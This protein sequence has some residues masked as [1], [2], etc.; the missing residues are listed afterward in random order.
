MLQEL[1]QTVFSRNSKPVMLAV[2]TVTLLVLAFNYYVHVPLAQN[3]EQ[4]ELRSLSTLLD[5]YASQ[6][7]E[8]MIGVEAALSALGNIANDEHYSAREKHLLLKQAADALEV[9]RILGIT[10][11]DGRLL[12]SSNNFP[13]P[14]IDLTQREYVRYFLDGGTDQRFLSGP[15]KNLVYGAWQISMSKPIYD[16]SGQLIGLIFSLLDPNIMMD[17]IAKS[18][19]DVDDI[20]LLDRKFNLVA[21]KPAREDMIGTF[22]GDAPI[23]SDLANNPDGSIADIYESVG[24]DQRRFSVAE[25]VFYGSLN[26]STSRPY[27]YAM[28][29]W[30]VFVTGISIAS[31]VLLVFMVAIL[32]FIHL[33][34]I[35][36]QRYNDK[37]KV[38]NK[39]L[40][41][42]R[43]NAEKLAQI[44][45]DFL[46]NMSHEIRTPMNAI[47]G[48]TQL[49]KRTPL[50]HHQLE[51]VRQ[52]G[53]SGKFLLGVIDEILTFSKIQANELTLDHEPFVLPDVI[54]NVGSIMSMSVNDKPI[55][56]II[57]VA[58]DVPRSIVGDSHRLQQVLVNL[59]SNAIKFTEAGYVKL[60]V[61]TEKT[62]DHPAQLCF[63]VTD[64]GIGIPENTQKHIF[65][66]FTQADA[67]T[68]RK[69][70]GTGLGLAISHRLATGMG[71]G[72]LLSSQPG[73]GST[74]TLKIPLKIGPADIAPA[75]AFDRKDNLRVLIV[76][77][78][79]QTR[80][81]LKAIAQ[82]LFVDADTAPDGKTAI[83]MLV[84][85]KKPYD[86]LMI[87]W[88]MPEL[89][90]LAT[91]DSIPGEKL[92]KMPA[93]IMVTAYERELLAQTGN[94][95]NYEFLTKPVTGSSFFNAITAVSRTE[96]ALRP[97]SNSQSKM[98][99]DTLH[100]YHIL[101][102]EDNAVNQQVAKG[103]LTS[104][105]AEVQI[106]RNGIE[107][108]DAID[109]NNFDIV[110]MDVQMPEMTGIEATQRIRAAYPDL[111][112]PIIALTAGVLENE[113]QKCRDSGMND[114][115]GKPFDFELIIS[116]IL[117]HTSQKKAPPQKQ[118]GEHPTSLKTETTQSWANLP[119]L[120]EDRGLEL[121]AGSIELYHR[122]CTLFGPQTQECQKQMQIALNNRDKKALAEQLH[123]MKGS[124][125]QI[126]AMRIAEMSA[127]LERFAIDDNVASLDDLM[128]EFE[129]ILAE[130][131]ARLEQVLAAAK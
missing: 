26:I 47:F 27:D 50:E 4:R 96:A 12:H 100:G 78:Q 24:A 32:W 59:I 29:N 76:D 87:D 19:N 7:E 97:G 6:I 84:H 65:D 60:E 99:E 118:Q 112:L 21:Q 53:L 113:Q 74:F 58:A 62:A 86:I 5:G 77:D 104:M 63:A 64:T 121:T 73:K 3:A 25:R 15:T 119:I 9:V 82:S 57:D 80:D 75:L 67:S 66:P 94:V 88:Q 42:E 41:H 71:G 37:L 90:G 11:G 39:E 127:Q 93:I 103:L 101:V 8:Q 48:L 131:L 69:F 10:D 91:I 108:V 129:T 126:A 125:A 45:E 20:S 85:A 52:I 106:A 115:V 40:E 122:L 34:T 61:Y 72:I 124:S 120:D 79:E 111:D 83:E 114:F 105:G 51:Y 68:T 38:M 56:A 28:Q 13:P 14:N 123:I 81:A 89:D 110:L 109:K 49:L 44:K 30:K 117:K 98:S 1:R 2:L 55:E 54:D 128:P 17:R 46:A 35:A 130:T 36:T 16:K 102:A 116:K 43:A 22:A 18:S 33:R 95:K 23:Y 31:A 92:K 70:G 107:A